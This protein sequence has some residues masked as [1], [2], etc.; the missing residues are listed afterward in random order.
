MMPNGQQPALHVG[1]FVQPFNYD[2]TVADSSHPQLGTMVLITVHGPTGDVQFLL[3]LR[4]AQI[5]ASK[6]AA[7]VEAAGRRSPLI[8]PTVEV[9]KDL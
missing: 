5:V 2:V 1:R 8:V 7:G 4:G 6:I 9:P 3:P